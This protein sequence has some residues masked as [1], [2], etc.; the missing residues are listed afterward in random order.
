MIRHANHYVK[1]FFI[2][3]FMATLWLACFSLALILNFHEFRQTHQLEHSSIRHDSGCAYISD[4]AIRPIGFPFVKY[5]TDT[6]YAQLSKLILSEDGEFIGHPHSLHSDIRIAGGGKYSHW[7]QSFLFSTPDCSSPIENNKVYTVTLPLTLSAWFYSLWL[8]NTLI[9][10]RVV[11]RNCK[12]P[13]VTELITRAKKSVAIVGWLL[14]SV[15]CCL[16]VI[17]LKGIFFPVSLAETASDFTRLQ[18]NP[19]SA[20]WALESVR[21]IGNRSSTPSALAMHAMVVTN[22]R[23]VNFKE[24]EDYGYVPISENWLLWLPGF[25]NKNYRNYVF[26]DHLQ[27]LKRG[28]GQCYQQALTVVSMLQSV[29][30]KAGVVGLSNHVVARAQ[31]KDKNYLIDPDYGV[32]LPFDLAYAKNNLSEVE[33]LYANMLSEFSSIDIKKSQIQKILKAYKN[34]PDL[35]A[36]DG[37][38]GSVSE[39]KISLEKF[40]YYVKWV[41][42]IVIVI[43]GLMM[44][45]LPTRGSV[46][47]ESLDKLPQ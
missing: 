47:S 29:G 46:S 7:G 44:S 10:F 26:I 31:I 8:I 4:L 12:W 2:I 18:T 21:K 24:G 19:A 23:M 27:S 13:L 15:G 36:K 5:E 25:L 14:F 20:Q 39:Y 42:P 30:V 45:V 1:S 16:M 28:T 37:V 33:A 40:S 32:V 3:L 35:Q 34:A 22:Q 43:I 9:L 38:Q 41:F 11:F 6:S 17:N